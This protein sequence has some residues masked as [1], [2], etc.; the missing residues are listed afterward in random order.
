MISVA[1]YLE[2]EKVADLKSE[3]VN[4]QR[5]PLV[6]VSRLH[7]RLCERLSRVLRGV[8]AGSPCRLYRPPVK[9][10]IH[11]SDDERF[12]YPDFQVACA[13]SGPAPDYLEC[14]R[15]ILEVLSVASERRGR[16]EK[17]PAYRCIPSL[18]E[19]VLFGHAAPQVEVWRRLPGGTGDWEAETLTGTDSLGLR[20]IGSQVALARIYGGLV[21]D[22]R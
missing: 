18:E 7:D 8:L 19:L 5:V 9:V 1:A 11:G 12:Y 16:E 4:G 14:P 21:L 20:S 17:A 13:L 2:N 15:L 6:V 10:R 3:Y 22:G